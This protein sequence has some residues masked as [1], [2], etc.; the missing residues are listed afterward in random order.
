MRHSNSSAFAILLLGA[1][2]ALFLGALLSDV[3][4][5]RSFNVQWLNFAAWLNAGGLLVGGV[6][7]LTGVIDFFRR[8]D[9][10]GH[11]GLFLMLIAVM[12]V[13]GFVNALVHARD[14]WASMPTGLILSVVV[15]LI[16]VV[17]VWAGT[18]STRRV[19]AN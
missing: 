5:Y 15:A 9:G 10:S 17:A 8:R 14:G 18:S 1:T 11:S 19:E 6:L 12:W 2:L 13:V 4:Y 7:L 16:A 3:A